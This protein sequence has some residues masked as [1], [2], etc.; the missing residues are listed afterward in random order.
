[1]TYHNAQKFINSAPIHNEENYSFDRINYLASLLGAPHKNI[2]YIRLAGSN[3]KT[4]CSSLLSSVLVNAGYKVCTL[5]MSQLSDVTDNIRLNTRPISID[6]FIHAIQTIVS[7]SSDMRKNVK[8]A[9]LSAMAENSEVSVPED[10]P[11]SLLL[12]TAELALT[13]TEILLLAALCIYKEKECDLCIIE[14]VHNDIDPSLFLKLPITAVICGA[15]PNSDKEQINRIK[16]YIRRGIG[17][18]V[19]APQNSLAYKTIADSCAAINCR[20][21]I[22]ARSSLTLNQLSF[23]GTSFVYNGESYRL[24]L[25]G[26]F[27]TT[28]AITVIETLKVLRRH[29]YKIS[30][31]AE[32]DGLA[33]VKIKSKFEVL[34][35]NPTIIADSTYKQEAIETV[36]E[37][38]FDFSEITGRQLQLMLPPDVNLIK[39]YL[40]MLG[41]RGYNISCIYTLCESEAETSYILSALP[42]DVTLKSFKTPKAAVKYIFPM[43]NS[44][45]LWLISGRYSFTAPIRLEIMR[46][47]EF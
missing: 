41:N 23:I 19:S 16:A 43:L 1:M 40:T 44:E 36:C 34:S 35:V 45:S 39:K 25:C 24:S 38:L 32:K 26:R 10:I 3:G 2:N 5:N 13:R 31:D 15:I 30:T 12:E 21:T 27:Q 6:D 9:R 7:A 46:T 17:E 22:P 20:L 37:S 4:I 28:N 47:L 8:E 14:S 33:K 11:A 29:G 18:V 42:S